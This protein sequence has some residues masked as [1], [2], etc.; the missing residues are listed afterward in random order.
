M[1]MKSYKTWALLGTAGGAGFGLVVVP[2]LYILINLSPDGVAFG[3]T[4]R[5]AVA[6]GVT[7]GVLGLIA[8][9]FLWVVAT[10][11]NPPDED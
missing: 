10:V 2:L 3:Q 4:A 11:R 5:F 1:N 9:I 6:N 8:G 7:W